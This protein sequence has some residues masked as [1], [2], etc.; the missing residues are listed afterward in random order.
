MTIK[1]ELEQCLEDKEY[2][3]ILGKLEIALMKIED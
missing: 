1:W 2:S 3:W